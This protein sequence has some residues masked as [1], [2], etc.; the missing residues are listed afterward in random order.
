MSVSSCSISDWSCVFSL[1]DVDKNVVFYIAGYLSRKLT[2]ITRCKQCKLLYIR[3]KEINKN[4]VGQYTTFLNI[5]QFDWSEYGL[6]SSS[7]QLYDLCCALERIVQ[8]NIE[9]VMAGPGVMAR[10]KKIIDSTVTVDSY[11]IDECCS[12]HRS[13]W[14]SM[15]V[16]VFLRIRIHHFVRSRNRELKALA[17]AKKLKKQT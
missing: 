10:L 1:N 7:P 17:D 3:N 13:W 2:L 14:L 6:A 9:G 16:T 11:P 4:S 8:L 5:R 12:D 15:V